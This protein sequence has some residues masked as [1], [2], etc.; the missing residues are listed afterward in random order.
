MTGELTTRRLLA[1]IAAAFLVLV[2]F[3]GMWWQV[4]L[5]EF[6]QYG[7][8]IDCGTGFLTDLSHAERTGL[9][10]QC[11]TALTIRRAW[12]IPLMVGGTALVITLA[13]RG[14]RVSRPVSSAPPTP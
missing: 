7:I 9:T 6:D 2:G 11:E 13:L 10:A 14:S 4:Y 3:L 5:G 1:M 8:Q 12:S